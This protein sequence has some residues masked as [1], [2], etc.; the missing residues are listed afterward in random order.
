MR[1]AVVYPLECWILFYLY[2]F[3][4]LDQSGYEIVEVGRFDVADGDNA[5]VWCTGGVE[6]ESCA[7]AG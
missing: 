3:L 7:V 2:G 4:R 6:R 5:Q 1:D